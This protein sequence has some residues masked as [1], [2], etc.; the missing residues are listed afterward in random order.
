M[1]KRYLILLST[2][3]ILGGSA[4]GQSKVG[5]TAANF[6]TI[7]VGPRASGMGGAFVAIANDVTAAFWNTGGL[8][9]LTDN[10]FIVT[11]ADWLVGTS[12]NWVGISFKLDEDDAVAVSVNQLYYGT[13]EIT[14]AMEPQGTGQLWDAQDIAVGLSYAR[15]LTDRFSIGGTF[16]YINQRVWSESATAFALDVGLLFTTQYNGLRIGMNIANFGT[17]MKLDG[18]DLLQPIDVDPAHTGNNKNIAGTL[19]TDSWPLPLTFTV[20]LGMDPVKTE[21]WKW[22]VGA[23]AIY[24]NNQTGYLNLGTELSW[25]DIVFVRGG[26]NSLFKEAAEQNLSAGVGFQYDLGIF[27]A[28][29]D[30]SYMNFGVFSQISRYAISVKF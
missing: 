17:E 6:L 27:K 24:P 2:A 28:A 13:E 20:G 26:Y 11:H 18:K 21:N 8:S 5:T 15:N 7:P 23:D 1:I 10:Q 14:T 3:I 25:K 16:K 4:L 22:T 12:L 9:R 30:Y 29:V 19:Q